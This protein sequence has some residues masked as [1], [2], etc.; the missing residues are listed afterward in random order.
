M[1]TRIE[2]AK[3]KIK[4]NQNFSLKICCQVFWVKWDDMYMRK[5]WKIHFSFIS[6]SNRN[7]NTGECEW[8]NNKTLH[9]RFTDELQVVLLSHIRETRSDKIMFGKHISI[10]SWGFFFWTSTFNLYTKQRQ[11]QKNTTN[12]REN[13][14]TAF[15][16][17]KIYT[18]TA[19][20]G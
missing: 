4:T 6:F 20:K 8:P 13:Q 12:K 3:Q 7:G 9:Y 10:W 15:C 16:V 11:N 14:T 1:W 5:S 17:K 19:F 2:M 18:V